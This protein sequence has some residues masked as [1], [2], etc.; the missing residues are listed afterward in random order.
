MNSTGINNYKR[1]LPSAQFEMNLEY[2]DFPPDNL[3]ASIQQACGIHDA[4]RFSH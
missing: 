2:G 3:S 1:R 4:D